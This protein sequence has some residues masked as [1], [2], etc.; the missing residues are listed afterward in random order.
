M[1]QPPPDDHEW[2][3]FVSHHPPATDQRLAGHHRANPEHSGWL[4]WILIGVFVIG[5]L[6]VFTAWA[7]QS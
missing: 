5:A 4:G 1:D 3:K 2:H 7:A 6:I